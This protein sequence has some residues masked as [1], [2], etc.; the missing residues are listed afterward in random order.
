[1]SARILLVEDDP[2]SRDV[3]SALLRVRGYEVDEADDGFGALRCL[4]DNAYDLVF[5][6]YHLP[7]MDGYALARLMRTLGEKTQTS[8]AMVAITADHFGLATRRGADGLFDRILSKPIDPDSLYAFCDEFLPAGTS[9]GQIDLDGFLAAPNAPPPAS[10]A[11]NAANVL[12]RVR[13]LGEMPSA[14][15]FPTP[16]ALERESLEYCFRLTAASQADCLVLLRRTG[17]SEIEALRATGTAFLQPL[18]AIDPGHADAADALF[19]VGDGDSWSAAAAAVT[20]FRER[21]ASLRPDAAGAADFDGRLAA[22]LHVAD[23]PLRLRRDADGRTSVPYSGG[24]RAEDVIAAVRRLASAGL[25]AARAGD[26]REGARELLVTL[27]AKGMASVAYADA[28]FQA[29]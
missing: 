12:W 2:V 26:Q 11:R 20:G 7:E 22:Y 24:F 29:G 1:M 15:I 3:L 27:T 16:T 23:R 28:R 19:S 18:L 4:Q 8:L 5:I 10:D 14:A 9:G 13:G 17:L 21:R 25:V 6:D